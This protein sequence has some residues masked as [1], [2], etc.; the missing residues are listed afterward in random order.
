M[1]DQ[2]KCTSLLTCQLLKGRLQSSAN[3]WEVK[4]GQAGGVEGGEKGQ[5][6]RKRQSRGDRDRDTQRESI[7]D[8]YWAFTTCQVSVLDAFICVALFNLQK[9]SD[10]KQILWEGIQLVSGNRDSSP[11]LLGFKAQA[12]NLYLMWLRGALYLFYKNFW[13]YENIMSRVLIPG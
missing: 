2:S 3:S 9:D 4:A 10:R 11:A 5:K 1:G 6:E 7:T 12:A 8:F 13:C